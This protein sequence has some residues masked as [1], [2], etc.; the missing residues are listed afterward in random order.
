[1]EMVLLPALVK[2]YKC[3]HLIVRIV[4]LCM[5]RKAKRDIGKAKVMPNGPFGLKMHV[6]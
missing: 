1:M 6:S 4:S 5:Q 2:R 3:I